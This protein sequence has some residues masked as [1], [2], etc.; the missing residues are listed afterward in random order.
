MKRIIFILLLVIIT[1]HVFS[2]SNRFGWAGNCEIN[3]ND[4]SYFDNARKGIIDATV[5]LVFHNAN[6]TIKSYCSG[7]LINRNTSDNEIGFYILSARHCIEDI[8]TN[9]EHAVVFNYQSPSA[10]N[11]STPHSNRGENDR[12]RTGNFMPIIQILPSRMF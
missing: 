7:T 12:Q 11:N 5:K 6:G 8:N 2:Q 3:V 10:D 4:V 9:V 1:N